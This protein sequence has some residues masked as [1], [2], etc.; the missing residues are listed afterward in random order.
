MDIQPQR[1]VYPAEV[2]VR[3]RESLNPISFAGELLVLL[4]LLPIT[5]R[6]AARG[7]NN[8]AE[9]L[10][11]EQ[12]PHEYLVATYADLPSGSRTMSHP[13]HACSRHL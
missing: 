12:S 11:W 3:P 9:V 1:Y 7:S 13:A 2:D 10:Q 6:Q 8:E 5:R 4:Y